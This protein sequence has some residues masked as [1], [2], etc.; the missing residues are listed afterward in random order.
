[1]RMPRAGHL[2]PASAAALALLGAVALSGCAGQP[3][4]TPAHQVATWVSGEGVGS[5]IG[6][7]VAD[8]RNVDVS[9]RQHDPV[10]EIRSVCALLA[11]DAASGNGNLP[12]PD[13]KLTDDL[14]DAYATAYDAGDDC[15]NGSGGN[16]KQL[17]ESASLRVK[18]L[19]QL[20]TAVARITVVTGQVPSTTTTTAPPGSNDDPFGS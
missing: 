18:A 7:V 19:A 10:G 17:S 6:A 1:M 16:Q 13:Q 9:L 2:R 4:G 3:S 15:Y 5:S 20:A 12:T 11:S 8:V 14:S